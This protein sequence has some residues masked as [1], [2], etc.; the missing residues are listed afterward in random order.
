MK[1][2][3]APGCPIP[4]G[5]QAGE[6]ETQDGFKL[7]YAICNEAGRK[8]GT[9]CI[10]QGRRGY[11]ERDY[12]TIEDLKDRGFAVAVL[13]WRGQGR[14]QRLLKNPKKGHIK[15]FRQYDADLKAFM[16]K[17]VLP[18]C[19][20]PYY[21]LAHST[22]AN[23][24]LRALQ[25]STWFEAAVLTAPMVGFRERKTPYGLR[26]NFI[27][28]L[29]MLGFG[30]MAYAGNFTDRKFKG[31]VLTHDEK[32]FNQQLEMLKENPEVDL[33]APTLGWVAAA[34]DSNKYLM[35]LKGDDVLRAPVL[36]IAAGDEK[37]VSKDRTRQ[38]ARQVRGTPLVEV[39]NAYHDI[40]I[41]RDDMREQFW[42]AF[43]TFIDG[44]NQ[45]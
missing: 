6:V 32:R 27:K 4:K 24:L 10:F 35:T 3:T 17:V 15:D 29:V 23:V 43:D 26:A 2:G 18:D 13:D 37:V 12:E 40:W 22:G 39:E 9:V 20:P 19:P 36:I 34:F 41:E 1:L 16:T 33:G 38:F 21:G 45:S 8:R 28:L 11:I 7:R 25:K 31:N 30:Q 5:L 14:S 42:A 44:H